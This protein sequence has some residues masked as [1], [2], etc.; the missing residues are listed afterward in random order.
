MR[1]GCCRCRRWIL[2]PWC[3]TRWAGSS[4]RPVARPRDGP[5]RPVQRRVRH[6]VHELRKLLRQAREDTVPVASREEQQH[7]VGRARGHDAADL[8][9]VLA[10]LL[11]AELAR[12]V[13]VLLRHSQGHLQVLAVGAALGE[14]GTSGWDDDLINHKLIHID[15]S[16]EHFTRSPMA[17]LHVCGY[18]PVIFQKV[19][20][21]IS[22]AKKKLGKRLA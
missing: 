20:D 14:L 15:S 5:L 13:E 1:C 6:R 12:R 19:I 21:E 10:H 4:I 9:R 7:L 3:A 16:V 11:V 8:P 17:K 18:L 22:E 2:Q